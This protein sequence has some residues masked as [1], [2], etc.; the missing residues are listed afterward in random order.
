MKVKLLH[1]T[2]NRDIIESIWDKPEPSKDEVEVRAVMTGVCSSD[3]AMYDG[4][5]TTLPKEIQGHEGLGMVTKVG[6][7][8]EANMGIKEGDMVATRGE[9]GFADYY[10]AKMGTFVKV[11]NKADPKYILEPVACGINVANAVYNHSEN[12]EQTIAII[13]TGF[14]ARVTHYAL[15][16]NGYKN[17]YVYGKAYKEY[18][19]KQNVTQIK[20]TGFH[21]QMPADITAFDAFIDFSDR[22]QYITSNYVNPNGIFVMAAE[23]QVDNLDFSKYLWDNITIKCPSPR[24]PSFIDSMRYAR[25]CIKSGSLDVSDMWEKAYNRDNAKTAFEN[26]L[27]GTD[28]G[29]TYLLWMY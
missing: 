29:R 7:L 27:N 12:K 22:A 28:K 10:N 14:L 8:V 20:H 26:K 3:V 19:D 23:K 25:E 1:T 6:S 24:D 17:F 18:W 13:G 2:G 5:F 4:K 11:P 9:P 16:R 21:L 15:K